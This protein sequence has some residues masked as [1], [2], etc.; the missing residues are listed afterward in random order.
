MDL[1]IIIAIAAIALLL[2]LSAFFSGSETALTAASRAQMHSLQKDGNK[3]ARLVGRLTRRRD[4]LIGALLVG[5]NLV[6]ILAS[7]LA[8]SL[9]ITLVGDAGVAYATAIMTILVLVF[10]EVLPKTYAIH[11][12]NRFALAVAPVVHPLVTVLA[13]V[14]RVIQFVATFSL[15]LFGVQISG[16]ARMVSPAE[17]LRGAADL[18][19]REGRMVKS[20]RDMLGG[21]LD[22]P[23]VQ[24]ADIMVH[25]SAI[26]TIN[27]SL[28]NDAI[29][30]AA[31]E[32]PYTR[33]PLWRDDPE[34]IVGILHARDLLR[35][36]RKHA[37]DIAA[38]DIV[39]LAR[40][41]WFVPETSTLIEQLNAFRDRREHFALVVDEYGA[42]MGLVTLEDILEEIVG[43]IADEHDIETSEALRPQPDGSLIVDGTMTLRDFNRYGDWNL[44]DDEAATIAGLLIH[45]ARRIPEVGER[46]SLYG[47]RFEVLRR[48]RNQI[49]A[50][51]IIAP[52][53][54]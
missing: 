29:I 33:V 27:S 14:V 37:D 20:D 8:T 5:N 36:V 21:I 10:S 11:N 42:L 7:A 23:D 26:V 48:H 43:E 30:D 49:T 1:E 4:R 19:T 6:N 51:R 50:L 39:G 47:F 22:L 13:P 17:E 40:P 24:V 31:F 9:M 46:F 41:P 2:F 34:N 32:S 18:H 35:A 12:A 54:G 53:Q 38:I 15:R 52:P 3:R 44:P 16:G 25:R 45:E 28:P